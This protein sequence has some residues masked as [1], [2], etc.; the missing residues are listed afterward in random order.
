MKKL[1]LTSGVLFGLL[2][3]FN[4]SSF[5]QETSDIKIGGGLVYGTEVEAIGIQA[6]AK[7][8]ITSEIS[9]AADF[10]IYFPDNYDWW[11]FNVNGHYHFLSEEGKNVYGLAG[12]NYSKLSVDL[13]QFGKATDSEIGLNLGGGAEFGLDFADLY[14]E[15]KYVVSDADQ[16]VLTAGLRFSL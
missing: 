16:L 15:I 6:G 7:Y 10:S 5:A 12:L 2:L 1:L 9:G 8:D 14:T 13:G 3:A 11:E 4:T